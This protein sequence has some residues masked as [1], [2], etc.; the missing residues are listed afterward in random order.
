MTDQNRLADA[1]LVERLMQYVGLKGRRAGVARLTFAPAE[2][3]PVD[4]DDAMLRDKPLA[5]CDAHVFEIG[6]GAVHENDRQRAVFAALPQ[7]RDVLAKTADLDHA[8]ARRIGP[9]DPPR[10]DKGK[11]GA[12]AQDRDNNNER[13]HANTLARR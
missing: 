11:N 8:A 6:A 12:D 7:L 1:E 13:G 10:A 5:E 2:A 3:R 4:R 9:L